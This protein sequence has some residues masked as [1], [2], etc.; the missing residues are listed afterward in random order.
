M[1]QVLAWI[2]LYSW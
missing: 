2:M 1:L